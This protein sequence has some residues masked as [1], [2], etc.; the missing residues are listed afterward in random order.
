MEEPERKRRNSNELVQDYEFLKQKIKHGYNEAHKG[1]AGALISEHLQELNRIYSTVQKDKITDTTIHLKDSELLHETANFLATNSKNLKVGDSGISLN[2]R[3]FV[4]R[5]QAYLNDEKTEQQL[6]QDYDASISPQSNDQDSETQTND[7]SEE[8]FNSFNWLKLGA[9]YYNVS[10]KVVL[11]DF[12]NGPLSTERKKPAL[13]QRNIDDTKTLSSTTTA[14]QV[15]PLEIL[16]DQEQKNTA[17]MV[18]S[19]YETYRKK[20]LSGGINFFKF[21]INPFS[22]SQSVENLFFTSFL[23]KDAKLKLYVEDGIPY[24]DGVQPWEFQ[25]VRNRSESTTTNHHVASLDYNTWANLIKT[26][27]IKESFLGERGEMAD[28]IPEEDLEN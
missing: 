7:N 9:L 15:Q 5:L 21:F 12:L 4:I 19:V 14:R 6:E 10:K 11:T 22:F 23:I 26:Y 16:A 13:R 18:R 2:Q 20:D 27:D 24:V 1:T 3:D 25:E 28:S 8:K 17:Y